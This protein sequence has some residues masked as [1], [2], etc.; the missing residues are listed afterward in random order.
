MQTP[1]LLPTATR[2][3]RC[4]ARIRWCFTPSGG[5]TP[6][7]AEPDPKGTLLL[8]LMDEHWVA[9]AR[10]PYRAIALRSDGHELYARHHCPRP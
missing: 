4:G 6:I 5:R 9:E 10:R 3:T 1:T 7:S 2:C 8:V